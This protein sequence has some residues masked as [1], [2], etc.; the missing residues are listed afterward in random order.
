[1]YPLHE[2]SKIRVEYKALTEFPFLLKEGIGHACIEIR[3]KTLQ[4][5]RKGRPVMA[6]HG[7]FHEKYA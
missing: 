1:M 5:S 2:T 3:L 6:A 7:G 4:K